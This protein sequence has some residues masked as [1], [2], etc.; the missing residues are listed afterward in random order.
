[1]V[2]TDRWKLINYPKIDRSQLFDLAN[3]PA[4]QH[5]ILSDPAH[6][7]VLADLR[8]RLLANQRAHGDP[9]AGGSPADP[10]RPPG[11]RP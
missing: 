1:M 5:D 6:A 2:R 10:P 4:E 7:D 9:L 8:S 3:D 11:G